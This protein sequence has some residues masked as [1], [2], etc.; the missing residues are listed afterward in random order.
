MLGS[1]LQVRAGKVIVCIC[2]L[3]KDDNDPQRCLKKLS[4]FNSLHIMISFRIVLYLGIL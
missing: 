1:L 3:C 2:E 4:D